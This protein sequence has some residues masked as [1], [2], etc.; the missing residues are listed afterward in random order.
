MEGREKQVNATVQGNKDGAQTPDSLSTRLNRLAEM[1]RRDRQRQFNNIAHYIDIRMLEWSYQQLRDDA[2]A[3]VD[4]IKAEDYE[5]DLES[6]LQDLL[7]RLREGRYRAQPLRR[8]YIEK[9]DGKKR[10]LSI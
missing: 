10:P 4:G 8:M 2:A 3:G 5:K 1:A 9:E 7:N 6:N